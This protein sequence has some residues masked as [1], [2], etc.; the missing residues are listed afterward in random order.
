MSLHLSI[1]PFRIN[2]LNPWVPKSWTRLIDWTTTTQHTYTFDRPKGILEIKMIL[3][4]SQHFF[5]LS[6]FFFFATIFREDWTLLNKFLHRPQSGEPFWARVFLNTG[7]SSVYSWVRSSKAYQIKAFPGGPTEKEPT[8]QCRRCGFDPW[9][10]KIPWRREWQPTLVCLPGES[11]GQRSLVGD[12]TWGR[13][14]WI[15]TEWLNN[16]TCLVSDF[17]AELTFPFRAGALI[18]SSRVLRALC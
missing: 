14:E 7:N 9:V 5:F 4:H 15:T 12:S 6:F 17:W 2:T 3:F 10:G 1:S 11:H 13:K 18:P 8:C 16:W